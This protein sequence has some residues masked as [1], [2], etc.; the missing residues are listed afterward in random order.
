MCTMLLK[1]T[2]AYYTTNDSPVYCIMLDATKAFD[3]VDYCKLFRELLKRNLP[4][5]FT[6]LLLTLYT[7]QTTRVCWNDVDSKTFTVLNGV[8]Q[9][10]ILSPTLFCI[11]IDGL[12]CNLRD[13]G[14][15]CYIGDN[16]IGALAYADDISLLSPT[17]SGMRKLL[18][19]CENYAT[20]FKIRFNAAKSKCIFIAPSK[21][22]TDR[23]S[24]TPEFYVG[25]HQ[26]EFTDRW[27]HLGHIIDNNSDDQEDILQQRNKLCGQI[28]N[29]LCFFNKR[30][31]FVKLKLLLSYCF[32][33]YGSALWDLSNPGIE[34]FC[35][36]WRKGLRRALSLPVDASCD[37]LP[38]LAGIL[39]VFD[40]IV[41]RSASFIQKCLSSD[42]HIVRSVAN[43]AVFSLRMR[44]PLGR[45]AFVCCSRYD[46]TLSNIFML[47][48]ERVIRCVGRRM[49]VDVGARLS[50]VRE[51]LLIRSGILSLS[52]LAFSNIDVDLMIDSLSRS[53]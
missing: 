24:P 27:P 50:L 5:V 2:L 36:A 47:S 49:G 16:F 22:R 20:E 3:R 9:G 28:N 48:R 31:P 25:G 8:K 11:Y 15:G 53:A 41:I 35:C 10:A 40:E 23:L 42:S 4:V 39:P 33:F 43:M 38:G 34:K 18:L 30:D 26:I 13:S 6:R 19:I 21:Y 14:V 29:V 12:L 45:N 7:S 44:S 32:S 37:I 51:L 46:L 17:P 52:D 1:E